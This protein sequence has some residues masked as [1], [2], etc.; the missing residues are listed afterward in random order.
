MILGINNL[1]SF[2]SAFHWDWSSLCNW[3]AHCI[4][5]SQTSNSVGGDQL[6]IWNNLV[7]K[8]L[9]WWCQTITSIYWRQ[10]TCEL[11]IHSTCFFGNISTNETKNDYIVMHTLSFDCVKSQRS[12]DTDIHSD[13]VK[14]YNITI[15]FNQIFSSKA[16]RLTF[17]KQYF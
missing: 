9:F 15:I 14:P 4:Y 16:L 2:A 17:V 8:Q 10:E 7:S 3:F 1:K 5:C 13:F 6:S 12:L 11:Q